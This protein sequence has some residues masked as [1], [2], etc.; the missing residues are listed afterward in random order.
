[1]PVIS[2]L[3]S[4][5]QKD[6]EFE[7]SLGNLMRLSQIKTKR[8]ARSQWLMSVI[9]RTQEAKIRRIEVRSL[10]QANRL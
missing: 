5:K 9:L 1:M 3:R 8:I 6:Q 7:T 2:A 10:F 4:L